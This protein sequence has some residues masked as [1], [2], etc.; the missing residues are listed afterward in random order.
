[1]QN[2]RIKIVTIAALAMAAACFAQKQPATPALKA[3]AQQ[4]A[5]TVKNTVQPDSLPRFGKLRVVSNPDS[6]L[7]VV[8]SAEKG[9][10]PILIDGLSMGRHVVI[11]RKKSYFV[12]KLSVE[13][14]VDTVQEVTVALVRPGCAV[15]KTDPA[16]ARVFF[17]GKE[18]GFTPW[19]NSKLK[20]GDYAI[21]LEYPQRETIRRGISVR[22]AVCDTIVVN[23]PFSKAYVDSIA[24]MQ[25]RQ[26]MAKRKTTRTVNIAVFGAFLL[27]GLVIILL[28]SSNGK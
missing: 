16:G 9:Q 6:A 26:D 3:A 14:G 27:F 24:L 18:L 23:L 11:V 10:T 1:M 19:E 20:P 7:V 28:E 25:Q 15:V 2:G 13:V 21:R 17:D 12:K 22:E 5:D 8:D 4:H